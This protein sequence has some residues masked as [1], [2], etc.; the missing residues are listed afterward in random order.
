MEVE[1]TYKTPVYI[2]IATKKYADKIKNEQPEKYMKHLEYHRNNYKK[3]KE[4]LQQLK[5]ILEEK[6]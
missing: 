2:R 5:Q 1:K 3:K 4:Q 6:K